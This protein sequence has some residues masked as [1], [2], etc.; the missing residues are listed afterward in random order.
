MVF[1]HYKVTRQRIWVLK[2][3][4]IYLRMNQF[5]TSLCSYSVDNNHQAVCM[6]LANTLFD[7]CGQ[8]VKV[9]IF[10]FF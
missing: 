1:R 8:S 7:A 9:V 3:I 4:A 5:F 10:F 2:E 6:C